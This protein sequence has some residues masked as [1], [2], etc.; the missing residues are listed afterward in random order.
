[1]LLPQIEHGQPRQLSAWREQTLQLYWSTR[2][3]EKHANLL[4]LLVREETKSI[5]WH[6]LQQ[7]NHHRQ[8]CHKNHCDRNHE[9]S[10]VQNEFKPGIL[11]DFVC[12]HQSV[13]Q[14]R[15]ADIAQQRQPDS[16]RDSDT[17]AVVQ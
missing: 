12:F 13:H 3:T 6:D 2:I 9:Q 10:R 14:H 8:Y 16:S 7:R 4:N 11:C 15:Y 17:V 1:M 5:S